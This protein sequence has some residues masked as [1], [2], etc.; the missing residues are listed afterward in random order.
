M[1]SRVLQL[2]FWYKR[3]TK[4]SS[5]DIIWMRDKDELCVINCEA[6]CS[7]ESQPWLVLKVSECPVCGVI[8][9][10]CKHHLTSHIQDCSKSQAMCW[11]FA[12]I[13]FVSFLLLRSKSYSG[14]MTGF[15]SHCFQV[16]KERC[17]FLELRNL[18]VTTTFFKKLKDSNGTT[19]VSFSR[20]KKMC[21]PLEKKLRIPWHVGPS[22]PG[23]IM[24]PSGGN[25]L[26]PML[27]R[28]EAQ[29]IRRPWVLPLSA[30]LPVFVNAHH[31]HLLQSC[32]HAQD[33]LFWQRCPV[34]LF[35]TPLI[36]FLLGHLRGGKCLPEHKG[37]SHPDPFHQSS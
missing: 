30:S 36:V 20:K 25:F 22:S 16:K 33:C 35:K 27:L 14:D 29:H 7:F 2:V 23:T 37:E 28:N 15:I 10:P 32:V 4:V 21:L 3:L 19:A 6:E 18:M 9:H 34:N 31:V 8:L 12:F 13:S 26:L 11:M 17:V 1:Y 24:A 5:H